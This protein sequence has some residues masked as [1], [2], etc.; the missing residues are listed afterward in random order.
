MGSFWQRLRA[1]ARRFFTRGADNERA[2][3]GR[4]GEALA[5][6]CLKEKG[7]SLVAHNARI[8]GGEIDLVMKDG[9]VLVFVE[10]RARAA[11]A[12]VSGYH[13]LTRRK[14]RAF[15][16]AAVA[17]LHALP[18]PCK[19]HRYDVVEVEMPEGDGAPVCRHFANVG[20]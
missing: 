20:L 5:L 19:T 2:A 16:R 8:G 9:E 13:S 4:L 15:K 11:G 3:R 6:A 7:F 1:G 12:L 18:R 10:V 17:Y 14:R